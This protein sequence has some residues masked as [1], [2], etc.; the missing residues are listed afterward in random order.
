[1]LDSLCQSCS[2]ERGVHAPLVDL[3]CYFIPAG[4]GEPWPWPSPSRIVGS[5]NE[6]NKAGLTNI[7]HLCPFTHS[8]PSAKHCFQTQSSGAGHQK[9]RRAISARKQFSMSRCTP[10]SNFEYM[11]MCNIHMNALILAK[12]ALIFSNRTDPFSFPW[13][14]FWRNPT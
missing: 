6:L 4:E 13:G 9:A 10:I 8:C 1:M 14:L 7:C 11:Y 2:L 12:I 3:G 5:T